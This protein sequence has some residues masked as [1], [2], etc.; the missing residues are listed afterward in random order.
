MIYHTD[1]NSSPVIRLGLCEI[2]NALTEIQELGILN[3]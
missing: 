3:G 1:H 2:V